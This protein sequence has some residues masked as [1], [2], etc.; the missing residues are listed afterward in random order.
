MVGI[1]FFGFFNLFIGLILGGV[2]CLFVFS[3][4]LGELYF[5]CGLCGMGF[6]GILVLMGGG[7]GV[8]EIIISGGVGEVLLFMGDWCGVM[9]VLFWRLG[10][11]EV[12][13]LGELIEGDDGFE[14]VVD[15]L[16][17]GGLG[18]FDFLL[19]FV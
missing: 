9:G 6:D 13:W 17:V 4:F 3:V 12:W 2:G 19:D 18:D 1:V 15:C 16:W 8:F 7:W 11:L 10:V 14:D 5:L